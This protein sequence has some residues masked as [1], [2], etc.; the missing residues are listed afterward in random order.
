M[1]PAA[2]L[3]RWAVFHRVADPNCAPQESGELDVNKYAGAGK[4]NELLQKLAARR[5]APYYKRNQ[6]RVCSFW[7]RGECKRG[8]ECPYRHEMP[9]SGPLSEQNIKDR[10]Y[11]GRGRG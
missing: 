6:A 5:A 11:G 9:E 4:P 7:V 8:A 2:V 1:A 10:Y 3:G